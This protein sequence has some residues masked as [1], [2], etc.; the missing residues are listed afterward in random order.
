MLKALKEADKAAAL[1]E[2]PVGCVI[3]LN[4]KVIAAAHNLR[5][6]KQKTTAHAE[7]LAIEKA[8]KKLGSWRLEGCDMYVTLE[9]CSM[10]SGAIIQARIKNLY[11]GAKDLKTGAC[12]SVFNIHNYPFNHQVQVKG[13]ILEEE[14][15]KKLKEFFKSLRNSQKG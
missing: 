11:F 1:L 5:E 13:G 3:V 15:S 9:P 7:I 14:C 10:C 4:N 2:V 8:C 6:T 12:G